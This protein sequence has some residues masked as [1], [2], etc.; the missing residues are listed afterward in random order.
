VTSVRALAAFVG[1]ELPQHRHPKPVLR[2]TL[3][4]PEVT[5]A[6]RA[7]TRQLPGRGPDDHVRLAAVLAVMSVWPARSADLAALR[8][9]Q[10]RARGGDLLLDLGAP[11][12][13]QLVLQGPAATRVREWLDVREGLVGALLG[14]PVYALWTS[15]RS[16][17]RPGPRGSLPLPPGM[18]L[19]P[20]GLQRAYARSVEAANAVHHG[21]PGFPLPR[22]LDL[23]RRSLSTAAARDRA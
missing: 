3:T 23:L 1:A 19:R 2:D 11:D 9:T 5:A 13:D 12:D 10:L 20:R 4:E 7:L 16:N 22:S 6:L 15:I 8:V 21:L 17:S 18:P 14:G